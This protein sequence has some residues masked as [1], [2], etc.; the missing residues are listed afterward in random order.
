MF[1]FI[2]DKEERDIKLYEAENVSFVF[3]LIFLMTA[4]LFGAFFVLSKWFSIE[5]TLNYGY[6][7]PWSLIKWLLV[8]AAASFVLTLI[9]HRINERRWS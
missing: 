1:E 2:T 8:A 6:T 5:L 7:Y 9:L 4:F 3:T